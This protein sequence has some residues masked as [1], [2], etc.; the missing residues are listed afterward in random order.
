MG[1]QTLGKIA[2]HIGKNKFFSNTIWIISGKIFQMAL[3]LVVGMITARYL[4]PSNYGV[5]GYTASYVAFFTSIANLGF[6]NVAVKEFL[7]KPEEQGKTLGTMIGFRIFSG[8]LSM[9]AILVLVY[10]LDDGDAL[11]IKV[12]FLQSLALVFQAFE[13][14]TYWYQ[15]RLEAKSSVK[16]E[17][18]AYIIV[19]AYKIAILIQQ[20]NVVWFAFTTTLDALVIAVF[21]LISYYQKKKQELS[22]SICRGKE[23]LRKSYHFIISGLMVAIYTQMDRIMLKQMLNEYIVGLYSSAMNI[24][25]MWGFILAA[26]INSAQPVIISSKGKNNELYI[27]QIKRL[28][29]SIIWIGIFVAGGISL[30]SKFVIGNMYGKDYL[31]ASGTLTISVWFEIFAMLGTARGIWCMCENKVK[32]I[33]YYLGIGA[34]LNVA[35]NYFLIP[36]YGPSGAAVATLVTQFVTSVIAPALF[37]ETRIHT[38]YVIE[39]F[40]LKGIK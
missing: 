9:T 7:D 20:K 38:K 39:A 17:T 1:R 24:S 8:F 36:I 6:C 5:I 12:A 14:I 35:L 11:I 26:I 3:Q 10:I 28:Y 29:S 21:L 30:C 22:F 34:V 40:L 13:M 19:A 18:V 31:S 16:I 27:K 15:S 25:S 2:A 33:K 23:I 4:G 32:Y 37:K